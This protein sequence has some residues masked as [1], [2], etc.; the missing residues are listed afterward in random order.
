M[1]G[2]YPGNYPKLGKDYVLYDARNWTRIK[3]SQA[4]EIREQ[5]FFAPAS[6]A[7]GYVFLDDPASDDEIEDL[8]DAQGGE[9]NED[10][11]MNAPVAEVSRG[12]A[13]ISASG[14]LQSV[15]DFLYDVGFDASAL[16]GNYHELVSLVQERCGFPVG[17]P[18]SDEEN[19]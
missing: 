14:L 9:P 15:K 19:E 3:I 10:V 11:E 2:S 17:A 5:D 6:Q 12:A 7:Y 8:N 4:E 18:V 16:K 13:A 1:R